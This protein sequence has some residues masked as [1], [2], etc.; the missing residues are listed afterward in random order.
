ML[1][2]LTYFLLL[3]SPLLAAKIQEKVLICGAARN[4]EHAIPNTIHSIELLGEQFLDY[5]AIIY[6]NNSKDATSELFQAWAD[7][8]PHVIFLS[9][10]IEKKELV[11]ELE[12]R[13]SNRTES[14]ARARNKVLDVAMQSCYDDY[15]YIIW[16]DLDFTK[17]WD[18]ENVVDTILHPEQEWDAV[19][20]NGSYD[21]FAFRDPEFPIGFELLGDE[22]WTRLSEIYDRLSLQGAWRRVYS[23]FGGLGIYK[24]E[25]IRGCRYSGVVTRDMEKVVLSWLAQAENN[26]NT[27]F[28]QDYKKRLATWT[29]IDLKEKRLADRKEFPEE[30][31][32]RLHNK[33][34]LGQVVWFSCNKHST[35]P[36]TCEHITLH[37]SMALQGHAN[38]FINPRLI[39]KL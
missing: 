14:I 5:R 15:T 18:V 22:Y 8:N 1:F 36:W 17:P 28:L 39:S 25:S 29:I 35:L 26:P 3:M 12:M 27:C 33:H 20:A 13:R 34:G 16:A 23:A 19:L 2:F 21:L 31:G 24:R 30:L 10:Y 9:E 37:A 32:M 38:I 6:E 4:V 7:R 11:K